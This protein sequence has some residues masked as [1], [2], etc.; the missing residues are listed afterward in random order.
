MDTDK[1]F[2]CR[3]R[4]VRG[5]KPGDRYWHLYLG[6]AV[7][8]VSL[9]ARSSAF[10]WAPL[11]ITAV[12]VAV[13]L[14]LGGLALRN[15]MRMRW[16]YYS[17][18]IL[19]LL[20][21][22]G[23]PM[24]VLD[25]ELAPQRWSPLG[26]GSFAFTHEA[27]WSFVMVVTIGM[28]GLMAGQYLARDHMA[29]KRVARFHVI[30][31]RF[32]SWIC[33][34]AALMLANTIINM[35]FNIGT[36]TTTPVALPFHITG[37]LNVNRTYVLP[38][39]GLWL[40]GLA[41]ERGKIKPAVAMLVANLAFGM[42]AIVATLSKGSLFGTFAPYVFCLAV[43]R[44]QFAIAPMLLKK[45]LLALVILVPFSIIGANILR[46]YS[47]MN[48]EVRGIGEVASNM[49]ISAARAGNPVVAEL[50]SSTFLRVLGGNE[51]M[52]LMEVE[53][54]PL[55]SLIPIMTT[56]D[57]LGMSDIIYQGFNID[58]TTMPGQGR[59]TGLFGFWCLAGSLWVLF[60]ACALS[61][62][63]MIGAERI[64]KPFGN[65]ALSAGVGFLI[66]LMLWENAC[67]M[68]PLFAVALF[69]VYMFLRL[70]CYRRATTADLSPVDSQQSS[71]RANN[72]PPH[73]HISINRQIG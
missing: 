2:N 11:R 27:Y 19:A 34:W 61:G 71:A 47:L 56:E 24:R 22:V 72:S 26:Y 12:Q 8:V 64:V 52:A 58:L 51:L 3:N 67:D 65:S 13:L 7:V 16:A 9:V 15:G 31:I 45:V 28:C 25:I 32:T 62:A 57:K 70:F 1:Q 14:A 69:V 43:N 41:L 17:P 50:Y 68:I 23:Y 44:K 59:A 5:N 66:T 35:R 49:D 39:M 38:L 46:Y 29:E 33:I 37:L 20:Y 10:S 53:K 18:L 6:I 36:L 60:G 30:P 63:A 42:L 54:I 4:S 48:G 73:L 55:H 21:I 40:F